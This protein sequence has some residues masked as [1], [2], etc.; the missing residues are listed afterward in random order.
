MYVMKASELRKQSTTELRQTLSNLLKEKFKLRVQK[1]QGEFNNFHNIREVRR[2]IA[3][4][5]TVLRQNEQKAKGA[6][7]E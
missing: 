1:S 3:R 5:E 6:E 4:L 2:S 7:N